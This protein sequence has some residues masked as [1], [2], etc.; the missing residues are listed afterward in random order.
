MKTTIIILFLVFSTICF[1]QESNH[2]EGPEIDLF[3]LNVPFHDNDFC[4]RFS[5]LDLEQGAKAGD[6][7]YQY[8]L[9]AFW[10]QDNQYKSEPKAIEGLKLIKQ[11]A[12]Q[13]YAPAMYHLGAIYEAG[14]TRWTN[15]DVSKNKVDATEPPNENAKGDAKDIER[16]T[17]K[18][19]GSEIGVKPD[20]LKLELFFAVNGMRQDG[21]L[22]AKDYDKAAEYYKKASDAGYVPAQFRLGLFYLNGRGVEKNELQGNKLIERSAT[23]GSGAANL[24]QYARRNQNKLEQAAKS[25]NP[26]A[27][28]QYATSLRNQ[29]LEQK[30]RE[31]TASGNSSVTF[32]SLKAETGLETELETDPIFDEPFVQQMRK[33]AEK[34]HLKAEYELGFVLLGFYLNSGKSV[35]RQLYSLSEAMRLWKHAADQGYAPAAL[36]LGLYQIKG[37][38]LESANVLSVPKETKAAEDSERVKEGFDYILKAAN[39][40]CQKAQIVAGYCYL[41]GIGTEVDQIKGI[42]LLNKELSRNTEKTDVA[43]IYAIIG[44]TLFQNSETQLAAIPW[45]E[46]SLKNGYLDSD[47]KVRSTL[48]LLLLCQ[49]EIRPESDSRAFELLTELR[50]E[51]ILDQTGTQLLTIC[52]LNGWGTAKDPAKADQVLQQYN[53]TES[54]NQRLSET[55]IKTM[56]SALFYQRQDFDSYGQALLESNKPEAQIIAYAMGWSVPRDDDKTLEIA[57][58]YL[59]TD[60][61]QLKL[62]QAYIW[63]PLLQAA[64]ENQAQYKEMIQEGKVPDPKKEADL[65]MAACDLIA[66]LL[67][68]VGSISPLSDS[69]I[70]EGPLLSQCLFWIDKAAEKGSLPG[71]ITQAFKKESEKQSETIQREAKTSGLNLDRPDPLPWA[72]IYTFF[73]SPMLSIFNDLTP[74]WAL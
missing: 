63:L 43:Q 40:G 50:K 44:L 27:L 6:P 45:L 29:F 25:E 46:K 15:D 74:V 22:V 10:L 1:A 65:D 59:K 5:S 20:D 67:T 14:L 36:V 62:K 32:K 72:K 28:Y 71:K 16:E 31:L 56:R 3:Q 42:A 60:A 30:E 35:Q 47:G 61:G 38:P 69:A 34:G 8:L 53:Q 7:G 64:I 57:R 51:S 23:A 58:E 54:M 17:P 52:L 70:S 33:A 4:E 12:E 49:K 19:E 39:A 26:E 2:F 24:F 41:L 37:A 55:D 13:G 68:E 73:N 21:Y 11:S 48:S 9:G 66:S 18:P